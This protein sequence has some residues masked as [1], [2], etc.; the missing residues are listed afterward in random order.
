MQK[1]RVMVF[2]L[3]VREESN[4]FWVSIVVVNFCFQKKHKFREEEE[5]VM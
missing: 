1:T 5:E 4:Y 2:I 3:L